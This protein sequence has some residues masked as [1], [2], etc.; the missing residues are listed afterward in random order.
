MIEYL[1]KFRTNHTITNGLPSNDVRSI[2]VDSQNSIWA[3]TSKG[4]SRFDG[5]KWTLVA[6]IADISILYVDSNQELWS[7]AKHCLFDKNYQIV[8]EIPERIRTIA[9]DNRRQVWISGSNKIYFR[10]LDGTWHQFDKEFPH[11]HELCLL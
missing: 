9:E 8:L 3:G 10:M 5:I 2:A 1:Q 6:E 4:L 11:H 7:V